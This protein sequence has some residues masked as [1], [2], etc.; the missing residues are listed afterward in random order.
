[1]RLILFP[2]IRNMLDVAFACTFA[3]YA[4]NESSC[5][6]RFAL[7]AARVG[8]ALCSRAVGTTVYAGDKA[9]GSPVTTVDYAVQAR[10]ANLLAVAFPD[11]VLLAEETLQAFDS[12]PEP[13]QNEA[14]QLARLSFG[15]MRAALGS[16]SIDPSVT[17]P[18]TF[19]GDRTWTLDP[20]DG[21]KGL[22]S[23]QSYAVGL[24][25]LSPDPESPPDVAALT[26][27]R[28]QIIL[29]AQAG[30]LWIY[31]LGVGSVSMPVSSIENSDRWHCSPA[32]SLI[33]LHGLPPPTPLCC[34]S[35]VKYGEVALGCSQAL[36]Q[37]LPSHSAHVWD[38]AAG[39]AAVI[40]SGGCVTDLHG[41][42]VLF[43]IGTAA[44]PNSAL[45]VC[46]P[47]LVATARGVDHERFCALSR[48]AIL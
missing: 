11:D 23:G 28:R 26:L 39:I 30:Q 13:L 15:R 46:S 36:V 5:P 27:P 8:A 10:I 40:A 31:P 35:L 6:A 48:S 43:S 19:E 34:G 45:S 2:S 1:V 20:C 47:G 41:A 12:L 44:M 3:K 4:N 9:D 25:R 18:S 17:R 29:I 24:A 42:P 21:T 38:H 32:S 37:Y 22:I 33:S 7:R 16:K 14:S